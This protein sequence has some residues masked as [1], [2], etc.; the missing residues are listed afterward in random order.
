MRDLRHGAVAWFTPE[1]FVFGGGAQTSA[2]ALLSWT[3]CAR[4]LFPR[5]GRPLRG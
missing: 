2:T 5:D 4:G 3:G 1:E